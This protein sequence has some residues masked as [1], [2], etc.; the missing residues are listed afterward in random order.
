MGKDGAGVLMPAEKTRRP[1]WWQLGALVHFALTFFWDGRVFRTGEYGFHLLTLE[2][3]LSVQGEHLLHLAAARGLSLGMI[4]GLWYLLHRLVR[5]SFSRREAGAFA[6]LFLG[7]SLLH[8][9][10]FPESFAGMEWD[11]IV[12]YCYAVRNLPFY[13][14]NALTTIYYAACLYLFPSPLIIQEISL[15]AFSALAVFAFFRLRGGRVFALFLVLIPEGWALAT[16]PYRN[17]LYALVL[18]WTAAVILYLWQEKIRLSRAGVPALL[19]LLALLAVW[20]SEGILFALGLL[21]LLLLSPQG[22]SWRRR[23]VWAAAWA[24]LVVALGI[25]Q[26]IGTQKYYGSDYTIVTTMSWLQPVLNWE[27]ANLTYPR[28]EEDLAAIEAITPLDWIR[29]GGVGGY[30]AYNVSQGRDINQ[31]G[32]DASVREAYT[33][34][35][36]R[37]LL[38]NLPP[39]VVDRINLFFSANG[40]PFSLPADGYTGEP[41]PFPEDTYAEY[42]GLL[43]LGVRELYYDSTPLVNQWFHSTLRLAVKEKL[44]ALGQAWQQAAGLANLRVVVYP[45]SLLYPLYWLVCQGKM[46]RRGEKRLRKNWQTALLL[47][48]AA[49]ELALVTVGAPEPRAVYYHPVYLFAALLTFQVLEQAVLDRLKERKQNHG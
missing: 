40:I 22:I 18:L 7:L 36:F 37:L 42:T 30:R 2:E 43:D 24:A 21:A 49:G 14:H 48:I 29:E 39:L 41:N 12:A 45:F 8:L 33:P 17:D 15:G 26:K 44:D 3:G 27:E 9:F 32:A 4:L 38:H 5:G 34:A 10:F 47:L 11:N 31:S 23:A 1:A 25:P 6:G 16:N 28:A 13:W 35:A 20:R 19:F 46:W